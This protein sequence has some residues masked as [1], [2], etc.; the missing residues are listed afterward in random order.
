MFFGLKMTLPEPETIGTDLML[1]QVWVMTVR[2]SVRRTL[3]VSMSGHIVDYLHI[4][5]FVQLFAAIYFYHSFFNISKSE[6]SKIWNFKKIE[7]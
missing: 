5:I 2:R 4:M 6:F 3:T 1:V 7:I